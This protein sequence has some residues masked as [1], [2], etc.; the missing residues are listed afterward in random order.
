MTDIDP[1][2]DL[3][4]RFAGEHVTVKVSRPVAPLIDR[5]HPASPPVISPLGED[6]AATTVCLG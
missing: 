6:A 1:Q 3:E 5:Q 4:V 2:A